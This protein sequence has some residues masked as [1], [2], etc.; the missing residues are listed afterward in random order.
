MQQAAGFQ[1]TQRLDVD[2]ITE[3]RRTRRQ[4]LL[5]TPHAS[6]RSAGVGQI[7]MFLHTDGWRQRVA[8]QQ[9]AEERETSCSSVRVQQSITY[10]YCSST[11]SGN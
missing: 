5:R 10:C 1:E 3:A 8:Q 6:L 7:N 2:V 9:V 11:V 4:Q